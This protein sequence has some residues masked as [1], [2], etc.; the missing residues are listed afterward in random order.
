MEGDGGALTAGLAQKKVE[1]KEEWDGIWS[2]LRRKAIRLSTLV[3]AFAHVVD[4]NA[5]NDMP[6]SD[7][8]EFLDESHLCRDTC[9]WDGTGPIKVNHY[10]WL[11]IIAIIMIGDEDRKLDHS[12]CCLFSDRG[13]SIFVNTFGDKD[14]SYIRKYTS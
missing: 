11:Q 5:R 8:E 13:W 6:L 12:R 10:E 4:I 3:L 9:F 7:F 1:G 2:T 14:P